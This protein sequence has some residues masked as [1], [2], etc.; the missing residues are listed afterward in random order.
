[1]RF[2][3][4]LDRIAERN[5]Y[6]GRPD[7]FTSGPGGTTS[8]SRT[9]SG[10]TWR[11]AWRQLAVLKENFE[12][13]RQGVR[14][15]AIQ[16]DTAIEEQFDPDTRGVGGGQ[17]NV[18]NALGNLLQTSNGLIATWVNYEQARLQIYRDMGIMVVGPEGPVAGPVLPAGRT[19]R[20]RPGRRPP[21]PARPPPATRNPARRPT[22]TPPTASNPPARI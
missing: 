9:P 17:F 22:S 6:R 2:D 4:P 1:M 15:A 19:P 18:L 5:Q 12:T 16:F 20:D 8:P 7:Q 21:A 13:N 10:R 14:I 3:T 11:F